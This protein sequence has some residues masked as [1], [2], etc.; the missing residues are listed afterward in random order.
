MV[1]VRKTFADLGYPFR[2]VRAGPAGVVAC[3]ACFSSPLTSVGAPACAQIFLDATANFQSLRALDM[4]ESTE[5][6]LDHGAAS[7]LQ[8]REEL[9][10][11]NPD[12]LLTATFSA[13]SPL[14]LLSEAACHKILWLHVGS[15]VSVRDIVAVAAQAALVA[16]G[17]LPLPRYVQAKNGLIHVRPRSCVIEVGHL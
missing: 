2:S 17:L 8:A 10:Y 14:S 5:L 16:V 15:S 12:G 11:E 6:A 9:I 3:W 4:S 1:V 13:L 7:M